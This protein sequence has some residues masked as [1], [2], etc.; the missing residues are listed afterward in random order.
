MSRLF[1]FIGMLFATFFSQGQK[2]CES[3]LLKGK[4]EDTLN[5]QSFYNLMII[6]RTKGNGVFGQPNGHFS[7]YVSDNDSISLSVKGYP[8]VGFRVYADSNCQ[9]LFDALIARTATELKEVIIRPLKSL[10]QIK[11][12]RAALAKRET[13]SVIGLEMLQSPITALYQTFS[14]K[15]KNK[16]WIAAQ[17]YKD[18]Q[19]KIVQELLHLYVA[20]DIINLTE[21][22]FEDFID[23]LNI[24]ETFLKTA[25]EMD[26]VTF[27]KDKFDHFKRMNNMT[28][29]ENNQWKN[30]L[31]YGNKVT[32]IKML[33]DL[34][35]E[36]QLIL[37]PG[38]EYDRFIVFSKFDNF[39]L[40]TASEPDLIFTIQEKYNEY[41]Y[42]YKLD[43]SYLSRDFNLIEQDNYIWKA[44][45]AC[46]NNLNSAICE[47]L[48]LY[49]EHKIIELPI[50]EME[51]FTRFI[52]LD[53][54]FLKKVTDN[55]LIGFILEK[56]SKY[57]HFYKLD[58]L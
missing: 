53:E 50:F 54:D 55:E 23:F 6:N 37:L 45:L 16:R 57:I 19:R 21:E 44:E 39:Y 36:H 30:E 43:F 25:T 27:V 35:N 1:L 40:K 15:E 51:R 47:L 2:K 11:A 7:V 5:P 31:E 49:R 8:I 58:K 24:N 52:N 12:E 22:E 33:L 48:K 13:R 3:V 46:K 20:Y 18:D 29:E 14:Q 17:E 34:Y 26:L 41:I 9:F 10:E 38:Y 32:A 42:F 56:Q 4:V 28:F